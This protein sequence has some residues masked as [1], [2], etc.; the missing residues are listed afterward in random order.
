MLRK[1]I[2]TIIATAALTLGT[3]AIANAAPAHCSNHGTGHGQIYK[4]GCAT[5]NGG[6]GADWQVVK[7]PDGTPKTVMKDG[8]E[9]KL[10]K[11][12][13][14]CGGGRYAKTTTEPY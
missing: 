4:H 14:H 10:Y 3:P 1:T 8:K 12:K 2:A 13:R 6:A 11:C 7:N 9:R 5:G